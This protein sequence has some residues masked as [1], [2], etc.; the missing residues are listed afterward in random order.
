MKLQ[1]QKITKKKKKKQNQTTKKKKKKKKC[2]LL[3]KLNY[4]PQKI[5][6]V[7]LI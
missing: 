7:E 2:S 5:F 4:L 1:A 6:Q 3:M